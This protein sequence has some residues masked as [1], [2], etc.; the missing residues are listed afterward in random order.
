MAKFKEAIIAIIVL[1]VIFASAFFYC[2]GLVD[3]SY[4]NGYLAGQQSIVF[5]QTIHIDTVYAKASKPISKPI[6]PK[7]TAYVNDVIIALQND[8][9]SLRNTIVGL[10]QPKQFMISDSLGMAIVNYD[11]VSDTYEGSLIHATITTESSKP[12]E[13]AKDSCPPKEEWYEDGSIYIAGGATGILV[14]ASGG[15]VLLGVGATVAVGAII[16]IF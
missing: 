9:D 2:K 13:P 8:N 11:P 1:L 4:S 7:D 10:M 16:S 15:T 12:V 6:P 14:I 3:D 5:E